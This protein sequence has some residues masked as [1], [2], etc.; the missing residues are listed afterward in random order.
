MVCLTLRLLRCQV[1]RSGSFFSTF[2]QCLLPNSGL[3][4]LELVCTAHNACEWNK[5]AVWHLRNH[6][7]ISPSLSLCAGNNC[8]IWHGTFKL[9]AIFK[10][11]V[12]FTSLKSSVVKWKSWY[13][14]EICSFFSPPRC[15]YFPFF[16]IISPNLFHWLILAFQGRGVTAFFP[17]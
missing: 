14:S 8:C 9:W 4:D 7:A 3:K 1:Y 11:S 17:P 10:K 13:S 15:F 2:G 16:L 5:A 6:G 12:I